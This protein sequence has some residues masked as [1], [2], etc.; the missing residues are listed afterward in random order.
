MAIKT[1]L[2]THCLFGETKKILP[3]IFT[4]EDVTTLLILSSCLY[5]SQQDR[6]DN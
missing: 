2:G 5:T 4:L 6:V 1:A 3:K